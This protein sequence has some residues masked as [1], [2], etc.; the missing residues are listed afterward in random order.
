MNYDPGDSAPVPSVLLLSCVHW[1]A[2]FKCMRTPLEASIKRLKETLLLFLFLISNWFRVR[3]RISTAWKEKGNGKLLLSLKLQGVSFIMKVQR[4][5]KCEAALFQYLCF[6]PFILH[7][8]LH[9]TGDR[10]QQT[11]LF[12]EHS[13]ILICVSLVISF[14]AD[15]GHNEAW[16]WSPLA[17]TQ[18]IP[19]VDHGLPTYINIHI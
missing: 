15:G 16:L 9:G 8:K 11:I 3:G 17:T 18:P 13:V 7:R 5:G 14:H 6:R 2:P 1:M 19:L 4:N 10:R 12:W